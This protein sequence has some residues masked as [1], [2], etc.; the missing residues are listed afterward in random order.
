[1]IWI[2]FLI[3]HVQSSGSVKDYWNEEYDE[4]KNCES[5]DVITELNIGN[6]A[7]EQCTINYSIDPKEAITLCKAELGGQLIYACRFTKVHKV[8]DLLYCKNRGQTTCCFVNHECVGTWKDISMRL[9]DTAEEYLTDKEGYLK[10]LQSTLGYHTCHPIEGYDASKCAEDCEA[11]KDT[12][13]S[14]ECEK[15][16]GTL[17]CC[18]RRDKFFCDECRF[19]CTLPFCT[20]ID[21]ESGYEIRQLGEMDLGQ[22]VAGDQENGIRAVDLIH[23]TNKLYKDDDGRCLKPYS[24]KDPEKWD[25]YKPDD[26]AFA[27]TKESLEKARTMKFDKRFFNFEDPEVFKEMTGKDYQKNFKEV[28]GYD[29][30]SRVGENFDVETHSSFSTAIPCAEECLKTEQSQFARRCR[31]KGGF[32]KCCISS[33]DIEVFEWIRVNLKNKGL[34]SSATSICGTDEMITGKCTLCTAAYQ[35]TYKDKVTGKNLHKFK[36]K[37]PNNLG[38]AVETKGNKHERIPF[39]FTFCNKQDFCKDAEKLDV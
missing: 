39:A 21:S 27:L 5:E 9:I 16:K 26:F 1:M 34:V 23:I 24:N 30:V 17:K 29:F 7:K 10:N 18:I 20:Y 11:Y 13:L 38:G 19:C 6:T 37:I 28:Y 2:L 4:G 33:L 14:R 8:G 3:I 22:T 32:F 25:H 35:C 12:P 36:T 31:K 15:K